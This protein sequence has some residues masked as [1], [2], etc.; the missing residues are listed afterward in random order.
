MNLKREMSI[1]PSN[2]I[3]DISG[4]CNLS[5][6]LCPQ[7][8]GLS[9]Q[10]IKNM[11]LQNFETIFKKIRAYATTITLHNWSEPFLNPEIAQI[12]KFINKEAPDIFLHISSNGV[13]LN[14]ERIKKLS[15]AKID[16]LEISIS[17]LTQNVY[18]KYHKNG[19]INRVFNNIG[20]LIKRRDINIKKLSIKYLQFDYNIV[21]YFKL[22]NELLKNINLTQLPEFVRIDIIPGYVTAAVSDFEKKYSTELYSQNTKR[23]PM[24]DTCNYLFDQLVIRADG[25]M[26]P[27]CVVPYE[28]KYSVGNI[29]TMEYDE[30]FSSQKYLAFRETFLAGAN[31]VCNSC[32]IIT[33]LN[34]ELS[35][36]KLL[37]KGL[38]RL[39][40]KFLS[41]VRM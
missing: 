27:C 34:S 17:G 20:L 38:N 10:P 33:K 26:F 13:V 23:I 1:R 5:C 19:H 40:N 8:T 29:L 28:Q 16:F 9:E 35:F 25:E 32:Y 3:I 14:E 21:S 30:F 41:L 22:K 6:P 39:T 31:P 12:I 36:E 37:T 11:S 24:K 4:R 2:Y 18:E 7:G 15:G